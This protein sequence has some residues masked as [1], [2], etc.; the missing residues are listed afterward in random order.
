METQLT[1]SADARKFVLFVVSCLKR[2]FPKYRFKFFR[3][4]FNHSSEMCVY[5]RGMDTFT[6]IISKKKH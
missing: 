4:I 6:S 2:A 1:K 3:L 5:E